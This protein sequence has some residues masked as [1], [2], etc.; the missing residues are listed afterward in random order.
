MKAWEWKVLIKINYYDELDSWL[1]RARPERQFDDSLQTWEVVDVWV[2]FLKNWKEYQL[3]LF[4]WD[5][6]Y[7]EANAR[8]HLYDDKWNQVYSDD[9]KELVTVY[10]AS[11]KC[12]IA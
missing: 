3:N 11:V 12:K 10:F 2:R 7:F 5:T 4:P 8:T 1:L 6:I 9:W